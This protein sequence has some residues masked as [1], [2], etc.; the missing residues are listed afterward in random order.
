MV[1]VI[2]P[3]THCIIVFGSYANNAL[4]EPTSQSDLDLF[5]VFKSDARIA[6]ISK[7]IDEA[8]T[9]AKVKYDYLWRTD[10]LLR[11]HIEQGL[12]IYLYYNIFMFGDVLFEDENY[13]WRMRRRLAKRNWSILDVR[14]TVEKRMSKILEEKRMIIHHLERIILEIEAFKSLKDKHSVVDSPR[15]KM[16]LRQIELT[17]NRKLKDAVDFLER[18]KKHESTHFSRSVLAG[19]ED[20][21]EL[22]LNMYSSLIGVEGRAINDQNS[23]KS[24]SIN[25]Y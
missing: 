24:K 19:I 17:G 7:A 22:T 21:L 4:Q 6:L 23:T 18:E 2:A 12:D 14:K 9:H 20:I 8:L 15:F 5:V 1:R 13:A 16:L 25:Y 3:E 11:Q 10:D